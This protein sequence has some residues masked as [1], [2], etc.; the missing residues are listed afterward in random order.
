MLFIMPTI[1][2]LF[3]CAD[4]DSRY[5]EQTS[6]ELGM[7]VKEHLNKRKTTYSVITKMQIVLSNNHWEKL[8]PTK[9]NA[10]SETACNETVVR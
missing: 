9:M 4:C 8:C 3:Y 7:Q 5:V 2:C 1:I 10:W 6:R